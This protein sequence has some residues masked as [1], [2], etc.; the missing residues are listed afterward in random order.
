M[1]VCFETTFYSECS[2]VTQAR[3]TLRFTDGKSATHFVEIPHGAAGRPSAETRELVRWRL[4]LGFGD[5][6]DRLWRLIMAPGTTVKE[7]DAAVLG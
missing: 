5:R 6:G 3:V 2:A 7:L 4:G 1:N